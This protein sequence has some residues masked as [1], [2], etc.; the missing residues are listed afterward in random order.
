M[1]YS[2]YCFA[3]E[4]GCNYPFTIISTMDKISNLKPKCP[5]C[6]KTRSVFRDFA[7]DTIHGNAGT[8]TLGMLAEKNANRMSEDEKKALHDKHHEY[9]K[10]DPNKKPPKGM[11]YYN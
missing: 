5:N 2:F 6:G 8:K 10:R 1:I 7:A 4:G 9:M 3:D 11:K